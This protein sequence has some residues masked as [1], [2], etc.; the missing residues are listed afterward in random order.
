MSTPSPWSNPANGNP[1]DPHAHEDRSEPDGIYGQ[2]P[3]AGGPQPYAPDDPYAMGTAQ[4][5]GPSPHP[6]PQAP[7]P[8]GPQ[9]GA[10]PPVGPYGTPY[11]VAY[12]VAPRHP[13]ATTVLV[14]GIASFFVA[15]TAPFAWVIG[16]QARREI[17]ENPGRWSGEGE[18]TVGWVLGIV[19]S[20]LAGL[21]LLAVVGVVITMLLA[22]S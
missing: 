4:P 12:V 15:I 18:I 7:S 14:L 21:Y 2:G 9:P 17:R 19:V 10:Q 3:A 16:T 8:Y 5:Y 1:G 11:P 22:G 13:Q 6:A 20:C